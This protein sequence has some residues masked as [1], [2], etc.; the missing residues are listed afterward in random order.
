MK[1]LKLDVRE[2]YSSITFINYLFP[3]LERASIK[4]TDFLGDISHKDGG[5]ST[6]PPSAIFKKIYEMYEK[7]MKYMKKQQYFNN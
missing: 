2:Q 3:S 6:N 4:N 5:G 7:Y 1:Q